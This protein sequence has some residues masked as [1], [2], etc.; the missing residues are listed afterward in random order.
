MSHSYKYKDKV[1]TERFVKVKKTAAFTRTGNLYGL[2][3]QK[4]LKV[5]KVETEYSVIGKIVFN[6]RSSLYNL[7]SLAN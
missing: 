1:M 7:F 3:N 5:S 6:I 2:V 4:L